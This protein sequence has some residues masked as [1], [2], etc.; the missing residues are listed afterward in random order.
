MQFHISESFENFVGYNI[1]HNIM[2]LEVQV[3]IISFVLFRGKRF[4]SFRIFK[5]KK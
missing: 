5:Q 1:V 4:C 2:S 3:L